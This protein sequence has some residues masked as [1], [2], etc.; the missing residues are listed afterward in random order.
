MLTLSW[1]HVIARAADAER[2]RV[3]AR[4]WRA[5]L[6][7]AERPQ[8]YVP[9]ISEARILERYPDGFLR[10]VRR[11]ERVFLQRVTPEEAAGLIT[12]R[13]LNTPDIAAIRN[14]LCE[15]PPGRFALTVTLTLTGARTD[16]AAERELR[17]WDRD[18]ALTVEA[19][20]AALRAGLA[21]G[22]P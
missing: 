10:E 12:F 21:G 14:E 6:H 11:G 1:T 5:L 19:V 7:K 8:E 13:H 17:S 22:A 20:T 15:D 3:R 2:A 4:L 9:A 18:F 16:P